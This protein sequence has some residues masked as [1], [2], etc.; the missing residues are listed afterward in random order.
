MKAMSWRCRAM[1][2]NSHCQRATTHFEKTFFT[3]VQDSVL[4]RSRRPMSTVE[5]LDT[6]PWF[7]HLIPK[8]STSFKQMIHIHSMH[9]LCICAIDA[10]Q[11][12]CL[13]ELQYFKFQMTKKRVAY[14]SH[15]LASHVKADPP[16]LQSQ[17][18]TR[19]MLPQE[20]R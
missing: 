14:F 17:R 11:S 7:I 18:L 9:S 6:L 1:V 3:Y 19:M 8:Y 4:H 5:H 13:L 12:S 2:R 20:S 16:R 15:H 10:M